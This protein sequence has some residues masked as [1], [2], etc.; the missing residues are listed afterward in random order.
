MA[1]RLLEP[2]GVSLVVNSRF[3]ELPTDPQL[4]SVFFPLL[5]LLVQER[6]LKFLRVQAEKVK[7]GRSSYRSVG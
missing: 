5:S 4:N 2:I 7:N 6:G 3:A 1:C